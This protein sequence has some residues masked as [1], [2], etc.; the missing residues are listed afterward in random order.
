MSNASKSE[1]QVGFQ[2]FLKDGGEEVGAVRDLA[3]H[4]PEIVVYVENAG[5]FTV[6]VAAIKAVHYQKVILDQAHLPEDMRRALHSA[7]A[8]ETE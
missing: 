8:A 2:V 4:R 7:H 6:P 5:E 1:I 3:G